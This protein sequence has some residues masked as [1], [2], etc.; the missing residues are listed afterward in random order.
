MRWKE[1][2]ERRGGCRRISK[3][4]ECRRV[5]EGED[6]NL[7]HKQGLHMEIY[8]THIFSM[9]GTFSLI[10]GARPPPPNTTINIE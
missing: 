8:H 6:S 7:Q 4:G 2:G 3:G 5:S 1:G 10:S 9:K